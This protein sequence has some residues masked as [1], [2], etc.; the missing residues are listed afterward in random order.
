MS[1]REA[2]VIIQTYQKYRRGVIEWEATRLTPTVVGEA[3]D[4]AIDVLDLAWQLQPAKDKI[5]LQKPGG[6]TGKW[7]RQKAAV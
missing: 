5:N 6:N 1:K 7:D 4:V 3:L 2:H